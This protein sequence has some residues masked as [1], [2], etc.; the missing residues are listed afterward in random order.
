MPLILNPIQLVRG[1]DQS[2]RLSDPNNRQEWISE[3]YDKSQP[4]SL[5]RI[6]AT[7]K[8]SHGVKSKRGK[9]M[10]SDRMISKKNYG[11]ASSSGSKGVID[12]TTYNSRANKV[13]NRSRGAVVGNTIGAGAVGGIVGAARSATKRSTAI[14]AGIGAAAGATVGAIQHNRV[15]RVLSD[16]NTRYRLERAAVM[17]SAN[18]ALQSG[19][20]VSVNQQ[21]WGSP[22][23]QTVKKKDFELGPRLKSVSL[24]TDEHIIWPGAMREGYGVK[25]SGKT[26]INAHRHVYET[27][28]G[29]KIPKG[30]HIDHKCRERRC[31]NPKHLEPVSPGENKRRAWQSKYFREG[32]T[33]KV[34]D[35]DVKKSFV[36]KHTKETVTEVRNVATGAMDKV[37]NVVNVPGYYKP[38]KELDS[39]ERG[40]IKDQIPKTKGMRKSKKKLYAQF[41]MNPRTGDAPKTPIRINPK[42]PDDVQ[43]RVKQAHAESA[44]AKGK[45]GPEFRNHTAREEKFN[46]DHP[47]GWKGLRDKGYSYSH[48]KKTWET[49]KGKE[50]ETHFKTDKQKN[51]QKAAF[52]DTGQNIMVGST[53]AT[54]AGSAYY[55]NRK[56]KQQVK[57]FDFKKQNNED[58]R[59]TAIGAVGGGAAGKAGFDVAGFAAKRTLQHRRD[60]EKKNF[61]PAQKKAD[62]A[63]WNEF[64]RKEGFKQLGDDVQGAGKIRPI[65]QRYPKGMKDWKAQ[66]ILA[67]TDHPAFV[68]SVIGGG[69]AAG[70]AY[71]RYKSKKNKL[72]ASQ[73]KV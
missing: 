28:T 24:D 71:G 27:A 55:L 2:I 50:A 59:K 34:T 41:P 39:F 48:E 20:K 61:T 73:D 67:A 22:T 46:A 15:K 58:N 30:W 1:A 14:G 3:G 11:Q 69:A 6:N 53:A 8:P 49:K 4:K 38:S 68:A 47:E 70:A 66:R 44:K 57:K 19:K 60:T 65:M 10:F 26:T 18:S 7:H 21:K 40:V 5:K 17:S 56:P 13:A 31:I 43:A 62:Q 36:P 72:N 45:G 54:A 52:F 23:L 29:K 25:K 37:K 51:P 33:E 42:M 64:K 32:N 9:R 12:D 35:K 63:I 16:P